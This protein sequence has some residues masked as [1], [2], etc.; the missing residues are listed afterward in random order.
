MANKAILQRGNLVI[1]VPFAAKSISRTLE[2]ERLLT[3]L[4]IQESQRTPLR[5]L[6]KES[7]GLEDQLERIF[8][9]GFAIKEGQDRTDFEKQLLDSSQTLDALEAKLETTLS[10]SQELEWRRLAFR[11]SICLVG[12]IDALV[13][14]KMT[15]LDK[16]DSIKVGLTSAME[17]LV[18]E[19]ASVNREHR[20]S[21]CR[22]VLSE[23]SAVQRRSLETTLGD[24]ENYLFSDGEVLAWQCRVPVDKNVFDQAEE[25]AC[26]PTKITV[27]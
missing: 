11:H 7:K 8:L 13:N 21:L 22:A 4:N 2:D 26:T 1:P 19:L 15:G 12:L 6:L 16:A 23:L 14:A 18:V 24:S 10:A 25:F 9:A 27:S 17:P 3:R 20:E 5:E